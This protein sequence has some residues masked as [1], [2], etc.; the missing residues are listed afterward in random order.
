M[1]VKTM[2]PASCGEL[3]QGELNGG[4]KLI[5]YPIDI[6]TVAVIEEVKNPVRDMR[7]RKATEAIYK[8]LD[9]FGMHQKIGDT[10]ALN[11]ESDITIEKGMASSTADIAATAVAT[12]A[13]IGKK[14]S[15]DALA[16]IC[17][18][19]EPTDSTIFKML[20]LFD[21]L[22]GIRIRSFDWNPCLDVLVLESDKK[23]NTEEF[24][25]QDY[26]FL[27]KKNKQKVE[28]AYEIFVSSYERKD[29]S[30][31]GKAATMSALANQNILYKEKLKEIMD[32]SFRYGCYGVN[33]AHSGTVIGIIF[34]KSKVDVEKLIEALREKLIYLYYSK[35]YIT[36]MVEGG[37]RILD[38][39]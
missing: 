38:E 14:L 31:L 22:N 23:L 1:K 19:I 27:R 10:L 4:E 34:E 17:T 8:T 26:K 6:Y 11:I 30:L 3:L 18:E 9:Y 5:S 16:R 28:K 24:R 21:H 39:N 13:L 36:K 37:V 25:R 2:C 29:F 7:I 15:N 33:V 12:A 32:I 20:T 35:Y